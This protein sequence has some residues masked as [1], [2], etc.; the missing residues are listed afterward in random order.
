MGIYKVSNHHQEAP[1][2][3]TEIAARP[4]PSGFQRLETTAVMIPT[5]HYFYLLR[6]APNRYHLD[7]THQRSKRFM[8]AKREGSRLQ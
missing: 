6:H 4:F 8:I 2:S 1:V 3:I 5:S 7:N